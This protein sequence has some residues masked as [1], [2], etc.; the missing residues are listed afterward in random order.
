MGIFSNL[1]K[2]APP[3][4][5]QPHPDWPWTLN[6]GGALWPEPVTWE[7]VTSELWGLVPEDPDSFVILE[8][9]DPRDP[10]NYW[11]IQSAV[12]RAGPRPGWY[13]VEVGWGSEKGRGLRDLDVQTAEEAIL[14]FHS[15]YHRR[16]IDLSQFTD[17]SDMLD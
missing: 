10:R 15:A 17:M 1:F 11:F 8:Q 4:G 14:Y 2:K 5:A 12:N 16:T 6:T 7:A 3:P 13:T 9:K